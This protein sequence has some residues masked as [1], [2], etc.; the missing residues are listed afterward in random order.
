MFFDII[1]SRR[2]IRHYLAQPVEREKVEQLLEAA[3]R[4]PSGKGIYPWE[5]LVV[6]QPELL[7]KMVRCKKNGS[8]FIQE[9]PLAIVVCAD[10]AQSDTWIEDAAVATAFMTLA[11]EAMDLGSCWVQIRGR[12]SA[13]GGSSESFLRELL[14]IP[15]R[16]A[17]L[18]CLV[19][20]Y[21]A[22]QKAPREITEHKLQKVHHDTV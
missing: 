11:A 16:L 1:R 10:P 21:P 20:G 6:D 9:A 5:F 2:S 13:A 8:N 4:A 18:C 15:E 17:V 14:N 12:E 3:L 22:E 19:V 7:Q